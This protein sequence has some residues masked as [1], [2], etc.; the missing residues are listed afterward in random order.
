MAVQPPSLTGVWALAP[1]AA[2]WSAI[3]DRAFQLIDAGAPIFSAWRKAMDEW[4]RDQRRSDPEEPH[5]LR[6]RHW[7]RVK[8]C[9]RHAAMDTCELCHTQ[10]VAAPEVH[11]LNYDRTGKENLFD[12]AF[13]CGG[14]H[15]DVRADPAKDAFLD[16]R[17]QTERR[18]L[19]RA[20]QT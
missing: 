19:R 6:T 9:A 15:D 3:Q 11:H 16:E 8:I 10:P 17:R 20:Y 18:S 4:L 14:C 13:L 1:T 2:S 7:Q 5:Y 12:V